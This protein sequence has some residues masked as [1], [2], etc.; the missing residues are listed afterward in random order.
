MRKHITRSTATVVAFILVALA[1]CVQTAEAVPADV[2][3]RIEGVNQTVF[4]R[5][6]HTDGRQVQATSDSEARPCDG[7]NLGAN[8]EPGPTP[9]AASV[10][11][12]EII[13]QTFDGD[14]Y[15][16]YDDYFI[17]QWGQEA[18]SNDDGWW[19]GIL[20]NGDFTP[21]GGCQFRVTDG[22]EILWIND[23][24]S[25][26][27]MLHLEGPATATV[28]VPVSVK[29]SSDLSDAY[30]GATVGGI[31]A[32][33]VPYPSE[34][35]EPGESG[36]DGTASVTFDEPGWKR[37]KA[38]DPGT[39]GGVDAAVASNS[40]DVCVERRAG[41]GCTGEAPSRIPA[42]VGSD[43]AVEIEEPGDPTCETD[44]ALCPPATCET[45][46]S[47]CPVDPVPALRIGAVTKPGRLR[48]GQQGAIGV[49]VSNPGD[50]DADSV[51]VCARTWSRLSNSGCVS[52]GTLAAGMTRTLKIRVRARRKVNPGPASVRITA[53]GSGI[54]RNVRNLKVRTIARWAS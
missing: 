41:T 4:D 27:P 15:P 42:R 26:R 3:V 28:G 53:T 37:L 17:T 22:D 18:Q 9:T 19:W 39:S 32:A 48:L 44:P 35:V 16:G 38:R 29:V 52:V 14:W 7:T 31:N 2:S 8:P 45:D 21:V 46:P 43:P 13:G 23:A 36:T 33:A 20:V 50:A 10:D 40:I 47:L 30:E 51:R 34:I 1:V 12:M 49:T 54:T 6:V 25:G 11:A 5:V 24:F